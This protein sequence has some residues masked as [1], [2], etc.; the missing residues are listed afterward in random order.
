MLLGSYDLPVK[1]CCTVQSEQI[2]CI[3]FFPVSV[4]LKKA[5]GKA[6]CWSLQ[7]GLKWSESVGGRHVTAA[8]QAEN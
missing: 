8:S 7:F 3:T 6:I 2:A 5:G 4:N 1:R